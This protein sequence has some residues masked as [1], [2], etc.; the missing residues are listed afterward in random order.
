VT[1][2]LDAILRSAEAAQNDK[3]LGYVAEACV[4][5]IEVDAGTRNRRCQYIAVTI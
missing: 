5:Q 2:E 3:R 4:E 1:G